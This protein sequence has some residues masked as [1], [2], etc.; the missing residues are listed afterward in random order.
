MILSEPTGGAVFR[1]DTDG[2]D[3]QDICTV[4]IEGNG[5]VRTKIDRV[6]ELLNTDRQRMG[7]HGSSWKQQLCEA[8]AIEED[9]RSSPH[10]WVLH[11]LMLPWKV[12][13]ALVGPPA[14]MC[15]GL[16]LFVGSLL[17]IMLQVVLIG[18]LASQLGC[19]L[20]MRDSVTAITS[21]AWASC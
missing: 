2:R 1:D 12:L 9:Q 18:D 5:E 6:M 14:D 4:T 16:G 20:G 17:G 7:M 8:I 15:G 3:E 10:A 19:E 21:S 13:F 11:V